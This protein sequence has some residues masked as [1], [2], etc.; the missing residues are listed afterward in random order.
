MEVNKVEK[1]GWMTKAGQDLRNWMKRWF[2]LK[3]G[4]LIYSGN[5]K[6]MEEGRVKG[7]IDMREVSEVRKI[8]ENGKY[9]VELSRIDQ[10]Y[11]FRTDREE[12][13]EDW[14]NCLKNSQKL[15]DES[16]KEMENQV[17]GKYERTW[18][19]E[20]KTSA[21]DFRLVGTRSN[22]WNDG[23]KRVRRIK[24]GKIFKMRV[25]GKERGEESE[26]KLIW[27]ELKKLRKVEHPFVV[28]FVSLVERKN[29][30]Y[31]IEEF[32]EGE[33]LLEHLV[34]LSPFFDNIFQI[35]SDISFHAKRRERRELIW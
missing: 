4:K 19:C 1:K 18:N 9:L 5:E 20:E 8:V 10:I 33:L 23:L 13:Q 24:D 22:I 11:L 6:Q 35:S 14:V 25:F 16:L 28:K 30:F 12:E 2:W 3:E 32:I 34:P 7:E 21:V 15:G 27:E 31:S 26:W 17:G 29:K